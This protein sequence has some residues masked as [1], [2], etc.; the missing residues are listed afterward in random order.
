MA[1]DLFL[2]S[3]KIYRLY[4]RAHTTRCRYGA[5]RLMLLDY[6]VCMY[7]RYDVNDTADVNRLFVAYGPIQPPE[8]ASTHRSSQ[9]QSK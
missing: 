7:V 4:L 1:Y 6:F 3:H 2:P 8:C 5:S 9:H